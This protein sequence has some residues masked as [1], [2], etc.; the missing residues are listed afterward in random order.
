[1]HRNSLRT[2]LLST[3]GGLEDVGNAP[4]AAV[5]Q[6][7]HFIDVDRQAGGLEDGHKTNVAKG[8]AKVA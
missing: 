5:A 4:A 3:S 2:K 1:M 7:S 6:R 8:F